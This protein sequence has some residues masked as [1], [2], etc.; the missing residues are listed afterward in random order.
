MKIFVSGGAGFLGSWL[1]QSLLNDGH[2]VVAV[3]SLIGGY[4]DNI[5]QATV[6]AG[7]RRGSA[8]AAV[9]AD[10]THGTSK[11][12][13][14][15]DH[16][17][18][19]VFVETDISDL[20]Q[21]DYI[22]NIMRNCDIVYHTAAL[23]YEGLSV[24][25]PTLITNNIVTGTTLLGTAAARAGIKRFVNCSSMARYGTNEVPFKETLPPNPEDPY[26]IAKVAAEMQL[27]LLGKIHGFD[28]VNAAPHNIIGP[29]QKYD[30][31]FRNVAS[32][33]VN[34]MLRDR[35]PIIYGDGKQKRCFSFVTDDL[36]VLKKLMTCDLKEHGEVFNVG[37]DEE[38]VT[39][40]EL[41]ERI[42]TLLN[43]DLR[44]QYHDVRP[45]EVQ[46]ATCSADKIRERFGYK[47]G[48][49]LDE[50]LQCII[51]YI[52]GRGAKPFEYHLP[53]EIDNSAMLPRTWKERLF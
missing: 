8:V 12:W 38:F 45:C 18:R 21:L 26:G 2:Y 7:L 15:D 4:K 25:S 52:K 16:R 33:M 24:F 23:A 40:N 42:A 51:D 9:K 39:I 50:G 1:V 37:P 22:T 13:Y 44:I 43:F 6:G 46:L 11:I 30:D 20:D 14:E 41:A 31:P 19:C 10:G 5:T 34:L 53:I 49:T 17:E 27:N 35:Q 36:F 47:T 32:I 3:D 48:V 29:R 28:V